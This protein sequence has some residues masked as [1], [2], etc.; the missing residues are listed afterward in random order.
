M[1]PQVRSKATAAGR[2]GLMAWHRSRSATSVWFFAHLLPQ[3]CTIDGCRAQLFLDAEQLVVLG[4]SVRPTGGTGLDLPAVRRNS[5]IR[6]GDVFRLAAAVAHD[7][8]ELVPFRQFDGIERLGQGADLVHLHQNAVA[9]V[10]RDT[11]LE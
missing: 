6:D 7:R 11:A 2:S 1:P 3:L 8:G 10:F 9:A 5:Q 4:D